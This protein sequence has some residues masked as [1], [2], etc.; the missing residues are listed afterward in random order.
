[1]AIHPKYV[2]GYSSSLEDLAKAVGNMSYDQTALFIKHLADDI[3]RQAESDEK[4]GRRKLSILLYK[5]A[6]DL[7]RAKENMDS[8]WRICRQYMKE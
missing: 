3:Q 2:I 6:E 1:M 4:R 5:T 7:R 8:V